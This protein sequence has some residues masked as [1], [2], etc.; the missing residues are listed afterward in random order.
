M[1]IAIVVQRYGADI[2]GGAELHAVLRSSGGATL[3]EVVY[4][5]YDHDFTDL[6]GPPAMWT[7]AG[8]STL[9]GPASVEP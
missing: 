3:A 1:K 4:S 5:Y 6:V 8:R 9:T 7:S 2:S